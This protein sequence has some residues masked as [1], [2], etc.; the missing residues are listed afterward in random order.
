[1][2]CWWRNQ[3]WDGTWGAW[4]KSAITKE[5]Q[6]DILRVIKGR[7]GPDSKVFRMYEVT[8]ELPTSGSIHEGEL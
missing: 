5:R 6:Q 3:F 7:I 2:T 8:D 4:W 1:M